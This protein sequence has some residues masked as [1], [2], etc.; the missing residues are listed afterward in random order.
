MLKHDLKRKSIEEKVTFLNC[1]RSESKYIA[2]TVKAH[3]KF[4][5]YSFSKMVGILKFHETE[6]LKDVKSIP[7]V[8]PLAI[9]A[10]VEGSKVK[11]SKVVD[12]D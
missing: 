12:D 6:V 8:G 2:R 11:K 5:E 10:K 9:F 7:N 1:L 3:E 4:K